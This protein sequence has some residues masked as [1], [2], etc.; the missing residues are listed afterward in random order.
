MPTIFVRNNNPFNSTTHSEGCNKQ[1]DGQKDTNLHD[2]CR[3]VAQTAA[4]GEQ[5][6]Q[7]T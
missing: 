4:Y 3:E 7:R 2:C 6:H 5:A 1:F